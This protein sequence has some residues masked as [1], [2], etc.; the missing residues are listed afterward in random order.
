MSVPS[1]SIAFLGPKGTFS[2]EALTS[3]E[4]LAE[5]IHIPMNDVYEV[6]RAVEARQADLGIVPL[7][8]SIEGSVNATLDALTFESKDVL[9]EREVVIDVDLNLLGVAG[10]SLDSIEVVFTHPHALAQCRSFIASNIPGAR[11]EAA[12]STA[13]AARRV[14]NSGDPAQAA[15]ATKLAAEVYGLH[16]I[17]DGIADYPDNA[18]RFVVLG[19]SVPPP[20]GQDKTTV[21]CFQAEDRPG[22]LLE[23]L[24]EFAARS[25]NLTKIESRPTKK[26]L[27]QY[28]FFVEFEGHLSDAIVADALKHLYVKLADLKY[29]G[30]YPAASSGASEHRKK[31]VGAW[32]EADAFIE[33]LRSKME[34]LDA[35]P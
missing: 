6:V 22:S 13:D 18:T 35:R 15:V 2:E 7:E 26:G 30:S 14:A 19:R 3:Q 25:I 27:G 31:L 29:L 11:V 5:G 17:A 32:A 8:N 10:C 23:I 21:V 28:C 33:R 4:D 34:R 24:Q 20:S 16:V 9:I 1:L 12:I